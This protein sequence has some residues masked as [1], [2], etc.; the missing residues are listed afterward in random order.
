VVEIEG[1]QGE[2]EPGLD[3]RSAGHLAAYGYFD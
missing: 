1:I 3:G 2:P